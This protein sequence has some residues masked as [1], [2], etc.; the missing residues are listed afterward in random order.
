MQQALDLARFGW[1]QVAPNPMVGCVVVY[2]DE[3]VASGYHQK[4]GEAHAEVN[5]I[6]A[7]P[8]K[9]S[10]ADCILYVTLEPCSHKGKT[11]PCADLII[12]SGFKTVIIASK[13][14]N[15]LVAGSGIKKLEDAGI[16]VL[17]GI[18]EEE[19]RDLN[20]HF[21]CFFE[22]KRPYV[23]LK[24]AQTADG[25]ISRQPLPAE[26]DKNWISG[27]EAQVFVHQLRAE[28]MAIFVGKNTVLTDNPAL[29]TR[30]VT[31]KNPLRL[32]IDRKLEVPNTSNIYNQEAGTV[33]FNEMK[34]GQQEQ[35]SFVKLN[36]DSPLLAQIFDYLSLRQVQSV[37]VEGGAYL[38]NDLIEQ[39]L[40][41][42]A[43]VIENPELYFEQGVKAPQL[44]KRNTFTL[45]GEDKLYH[46]L[47]L[48]TIK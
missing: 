45:L 6:N 30:W 10:P 12:R 19:A 34:E 23:I 46:Y 39:N 5:A 32:F 35:V 21:M 22:Q 17:S 43:F 2:K 18:L 47:R 29:T 15:P 44:A 7:L 9:L 16:E 48:E 20:K 1:P 31:G 26:R 3:I 11:P 41:D 38:L 8:E 28:T 40:W 36:F 33:V 14:P 42:E 13:D 37:L 27:K 24:W 4:Y 25:F